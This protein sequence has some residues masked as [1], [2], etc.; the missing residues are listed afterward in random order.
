MASSVVAQLLFL[1]SQDSTKPIHLYVNSPG[2][3]VT[4]GLAIYD[5]IQVRWR[6][7][8]LLDCP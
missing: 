3:T 7:L 1:E 2:G 5:T 4:D 8:L 6:L